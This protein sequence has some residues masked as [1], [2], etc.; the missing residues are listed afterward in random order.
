MNKRQLHKWQEN[1][2]DIIIYVTYFLVI[3]SSLGLSEG[4]PKY[5]KYLDYYIAE[6]EH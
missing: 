4:A 2:F 3:I 5:L 1:L 6:N